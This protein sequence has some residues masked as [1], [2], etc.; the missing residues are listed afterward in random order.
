MEKTRFDSSRAEQMAQL[1]GVCRI[2]QEESRKA[3]DANRKKSVY[4]EP[5]G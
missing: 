3:S 2:I 1:N 4:Q 5:Y